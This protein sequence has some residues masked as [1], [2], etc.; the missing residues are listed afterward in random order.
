MKWKWHSNVHLFIMKHSCYR[1]RVID[2]APFKIGAPSIVYG[3][4]LLNNIHLLAGMV[5]HIEILLFHTPTLHNFPSSADIKAVKNLGDSEGL[6]FSVHLPASLEIASRRRDKR[7]QSVE[8]TA[9]LINLTSELE[10]TGYILHIPVTPPTLTAVPGQYLTANDQ[11]TFDGWTRKAAESLVAIGGRIGAHNNILVE[12]I[13][14]SPVFLEIFWKSGMCG[15]CLD[16]GHLMLGRQSVA[17]TL[18]QFMPVIKEVHLHGVLED[19]EHLSLT[20]LDRTRLSRWINLLLDV[21]FNGIVNLE[22]FTPED[23]ETSLGVLLHMM[24]SR[25]APCALGPGRHAFLS[26]D[27]RCG[28]LSLAEKAEKTAK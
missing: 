24:Q 25:R 20:V 16:M 10:P 17:K 13:N 7:Q 5:D 27:S 15:F 23:L 18:R 14:Y 9:E 28:G 22:V 12:N 26:V 11:N 8:M 21:D 1:S 6:S 19:E 3:E 2:S 4:N